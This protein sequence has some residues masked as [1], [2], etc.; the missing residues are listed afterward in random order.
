MCL[1]TV[2]RCFYK[3]WFLIITAAENGTMRRIELMP[4]WLL[5]ERDEVSGWRG[6]LCIFCVAVFEL[7]HGR[8]HHELRG[9]WC[10]HWFAQRGRWARPRR[11]VSVTW[12]GLELGCSDWK[13]IGNQNLAVVC[14]NVWGVIFSGF[15][16]GH[17]N[18]ED[19]KIFVQKHASRTGATWMSQCMFLILFDCLT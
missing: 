14:N 11:S 15:N 16:D 2:C 8:F 10:Q 17:I 12:L 13:V 7:V 5:Y 1:R 4:Q 9:Y 19:M 6:K 18:E 3:Q